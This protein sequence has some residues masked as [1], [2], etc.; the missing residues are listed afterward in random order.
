ME[1]STASRRP[2]GRTAEARRRVRA[3]GCWPQAPSGHQA[4]GEA[5]VVAG[6][7]RSRPR[8]NCWRRWPRFHRPTTRP[9][10]TWSKRRRTDPRFR[11]RRYLRRY[12]RPLGIGLGLV[13]FD[14]SLTLA[15]PL[16]VRRGID[17]GVAVKSTRALFGASLAFLVVALV[18][19]AVTWAYTRQTGRTAERLLLRAAHPDLRPSPADVG[20]LLRPG[21]GGPDH[22]PHDDRRRGAVP[23]AADRPDQ[24]HRQH[25]QLR[26]CPRVCWRSSTGACCS[27]C[28][29]RPAAARRHLV[30]PPGVQPGL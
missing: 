18:D 27:P 28:W 26:R 9:T 10:S 17:Q 15:G 20:R 7:W 12:R 8:P 3:S 13:A 30:V 11:L 23:A 2:R 19:W 25:S 22:D 16:L 6:A 14:T 5:G 29:R 21:D 4:A 24:R 1:W